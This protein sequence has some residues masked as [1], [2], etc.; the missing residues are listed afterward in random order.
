MSRAGMKHVGGKELAV[1]HPRISRSLF[2][3]VLALACAAVTFGDDAAL[4]YGSQEAPTKQ[5]HAVRLATYNVL[6]LFD[7]VDDPTLSGRYDDVTETKPESEVEAVARAI[8]AVDADV[9]A[10]EEVESMEALLWFR[11]T[12]L[13]DMGYEHVASIDVGYYR[14][15]E[16]AVLSRYEITQA[17]VWE[18]MELDGK[19]PRLWNGRPNR[20]YGEPLLFRR[21]PLR[22]DVQVSEDYALRLYVVHHKSGQGNDYWREAEGRKIIELIEADQAANPDR[23]IAVLGD[24]NAEPW[25][26]SVREYME[27]GLVDTMAHREIQEPR[28]K[29]APRYVTH[30]SSRTIDFILVNSAL[31]REVIP[32]TAFVFATPARP[33]GHDW[34]TDPT[35][36]GYASDHFP[37]CIDLVP[38]D[39]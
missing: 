36:K 13:A 25:D 37:V 26:L 6:N 8:R 35:P 32:G 27:A 4:L 3:S 11:D 23:N 10:L 2:A 34:R 16:N 17:H 20:Y 18:E 24:F 39:R 33:E 14:G 38:K 15:I 21:S 30:E 29:V 19:H 12:Y 1:R 5:A 28:L 9:L 7:D 22:V 31:L